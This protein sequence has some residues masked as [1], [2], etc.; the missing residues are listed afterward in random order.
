MDDHKAAEFDAYK[1]SY[2]DRVNESLSFTGLKVDFFTRVKAEY[3]CDAL[4][5]QFGKLDTLRVLDV[6]CGVG[7]YH[8]Y[9]KGRFGSL[10]GIDVSAEC[11]DRA[12]KDHPEV[13][14]HV[15]EEGKL[16]YADASFDCAFTSCVLHHVVPQEREEFSREFRRVVRPG[17]LGIIFEH[18]P[19]NPLTRHVV[20]NCEFDKNAV[21][22]KANE[23]ERLLNNSGFANVSSQYILNIPAANAALRAAD[24]LFSPLRLGAQYFTKGTARR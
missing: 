24:R 22:L 21:L 15:S 3:L 13:T 20:S 9:L 4:D 18:N 12:R 1:D 10:S 5:A 11:I 7:N 2:D 14:Y 6:G 19:Y 23:S 8:S 16:P 17:G